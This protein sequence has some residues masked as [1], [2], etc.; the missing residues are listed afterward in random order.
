M[1]PCLTAEWFSSCG[2]GRPP[3]A[4]TRS[5]SRRHG[6]AYVAERGAVLRCPQGAMGQLGV[7]RSLHQV[8]TFCRACGGS[9]KGLSAEQLMGA[10]GY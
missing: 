4:V 1:Q 5:Q 9:S 6:W 10:L 2:L 8:I 7:A 3:A